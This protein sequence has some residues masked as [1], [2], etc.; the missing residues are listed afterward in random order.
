MESKTLDEVCEFLVD[1]LHSTALTQAAGAPLIRTPNVGR[2]RLIL[3]GANRVSKEQK[4]G[5]LEGQIWIA[6]DF[7]ET[8]Q[9]VIDSFCNSKIFPDED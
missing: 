1:C 9:D 3:D 4:P 8:P 5:G 7:D 6:P 2:G